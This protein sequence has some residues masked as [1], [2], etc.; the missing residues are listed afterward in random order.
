MERYP[1]LKV[2][3]Y[4]ENNALSLPGGHSKFISRNSEKN[5]LHTYSVALVRMRTKPTERK[6]LAGEVSANFCG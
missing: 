5:V 4:W 3:C 1:R 2:V 6:L